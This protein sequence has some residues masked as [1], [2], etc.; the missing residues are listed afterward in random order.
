MRESARALAFTQWTHLGAHLPSVWSRLEVEAIVTDYLAMLEAELSG[1][2]YNKASHS[3]ALMGLLSERSKASIEF[4]HANISAVLI[5]LGMP[6]IDGYKPRGNYQQLL[7]D[8]ITERL[9]AQSG[10]VAVVAEDVDAPLVVPSVD[11]IL[12]ALV[13]APQSKQSDVQERV[14]PPY[15]SIKKKLSINYLEREARNQAVGAIG[16]H[17]VLAFE[18]ARLISEGQ[19][20]LAAKIEHVAVTKGDSEG[21]D[22]LSFEASGKERLIEVKTTRYG[23]Q[24]PFFVSRNEL[25]VSER[26]ADK[27][28]LYRAFGLKKT[29]RLFQL[30]GALSKSCLLEPASYTASVA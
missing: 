14:K 29:A 25:A 27:Y 24:T 4:K 19:E 22:I 15:A 12:S 9:A 2:E 1:R 7:Y 16:E 8:V 30:P 18:Q 23:A 3:R 5:E 10:L 20:R 28:H 21:Y 11:D 26:E 17:F 6:Y 13:D